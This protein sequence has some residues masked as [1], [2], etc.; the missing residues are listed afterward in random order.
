MPH[1][2]CPDKDPALRVETIEAAGR[3]EGS[4][5]H[6]DPGRHRGDDRGDRRLAV[7]PRGPRPGDGGNPGGDR[8]EFQ[9]QGQHPDAAA[10]RTGPALVRPGGGPGS[11][12]HGAGG[13]SRCR[14]TSPSASRSTSTPG[15][16][17]GAGCRPLTIDWVNPEEPWP[18]LDELRGRTESR[19]VRTAAPASGLPGVHR[20]R[21]GSTRLYADVVGTP[22]TD[23]LASHPWRRRSD[24]DHHVLSECGLPRRWQRADGRPAGGGKERPSSRC[25][26][27]QRRCRPRPRPADGAGQQSVTV[28]ARAC[29]RGCVSPRR[30]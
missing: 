14:R 7:R 12:D 24:D 1:H 8:S 13:N 29:C 10:C 2:N 20:H 3:I 4:V 19:R 25:R 17:T 27:H 22:T 15:S 23:G 9:G 26:A 16:T 6:R 21:N 5:H 11:L 18:H 28:G 30:R